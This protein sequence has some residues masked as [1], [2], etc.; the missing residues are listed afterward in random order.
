MVC[1][2]GKVCEG[3]EVGEIDGEEEVE[4][5]VDVE[6]RDD[7][8]LWLLAGGGDDLKIGGAFGEF[9]KR[10]DEGGLPLPFEN[11]SDKVIVLPLP[12]EERDRDSLGEI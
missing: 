9:V 6:L 3:E 7:D 2:E 11:L 5:D 12:V 10:G 4:E 8:K 1:E